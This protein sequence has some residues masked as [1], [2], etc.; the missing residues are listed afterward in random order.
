M[1]EL[2]RNISTEINLIDIS[3]LNNVATNVVK[4][5][6]AYINEQGRHFE[7]ML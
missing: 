4:R 7:Y 5:I 2:K 3:V 1:G 6:R